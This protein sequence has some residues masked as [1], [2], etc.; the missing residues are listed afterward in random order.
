MVAHADSLNKSGCWL[1]KLGQCPVFSIFAPKKRN[2]I[3][4]YTTEIVD[5]E[6]VIS[7]KTFRSYPLKRIFLGISL[8]NSRKVCIF[9]AET[10]I[11][12]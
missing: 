3:T 10:L 8:A 12:V 2:D 4:Y 11:N 9:A 5:G 1:K 7:D 6:E